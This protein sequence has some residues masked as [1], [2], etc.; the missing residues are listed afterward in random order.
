MS[1]AHL[2]VRER[3]GLTMREKMALADDP[4]LAR[5]AIEARIDAEDA[6]R[7]MHFTA[8]E[9]ARWAEIAAAIAC[10]AVV[11]LTVAALLFGRRIPLG[12]FE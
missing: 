8:A 5:R 4:A 10:I 3:T 6:A 9:P 2:T 11:L 12:W 7:G 1:R